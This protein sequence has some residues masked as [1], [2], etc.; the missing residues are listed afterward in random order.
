MNNIL[1]SILYPSNN[2]FIAIIVALSGLRVFIEMTPLKPEQWPISKLLAKRVGEK[3]VRLF[4][5]NGLLI[6]IGQIL[7][8]APQLLF[9]KV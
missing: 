7:L 1:N 9:S 6:C 5:R 2:T 8:W 4:H 3:Q